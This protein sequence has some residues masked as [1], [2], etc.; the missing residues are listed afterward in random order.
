MRFL[1]AV[2]LEDIIIGCAFALS[3]YE[4]PT[5]THLQKDMFNTMYRALLLLLSFIY[6]FIT[7]TVISMFMQ[8]VPLLI[9]AKDD[10]E[11]LLAAIASII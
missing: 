2:I 10:T 8:V 5:T 3:S 9:V 1:T 4:E 6:L 11:V 7:C